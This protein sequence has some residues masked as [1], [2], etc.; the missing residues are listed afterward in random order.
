MKSLKKMVLI[1][2]VIAVLMSG[3]PTGYAYYTSFLTEG[4]TLHIYSMLTGQ[5]LY[6]MR[7][8]FFD[9]AS[10][11]FIKHIIVHLGTLDETD[12]S[13]LGSCL[14]VETITF[15]KANFKDN[16][17]PDYAFNGLH[18]LTT[19]TMNCSVVEIGKEAFKNSEKLKDVT[20]NDEYTMQ[21]VSK[22]GERAF[23]GTA[24]ENFG[25]TDEYP[26]L[27]LR[28]LETIPQYAFA[29]CGL[30]KIDFLPNVTKVEWGAFEQCPNLE[31][32]SLPKLIYAHPYAFYNC[33]KLKHVD[34]LKVTHMDKYAMK[35]CDALRE[36][37]LPELATMGWGAFE[38][39]ALLETVDMPKLEK[40]REYGFYACPKL[41]DVYLP[42]VSRLEWNAFLECSG[43]QKISL[44]N[45][46]HFGID[47]FVRCTALK[48]AIFPKAQTFERGI[49]YQCGAIT[50]L[51]LGAI[52][53]TLGPYNFDGT[54]GTKT[55]YV[56]AS[57][58]NTY[59]PE[60]DGWNT[61]Q[62]ASAS[63]ANQITSF[64]FEAFEPDIVGTI[65]HSSLTVDV[66]VPYGTDLTSLTPTI[67]ESPLATIRPF[68]GQAQDFTN[69]VV[70]T[71]MAQSGAE[72]KYTVN[73]HNALN[74]ENKILSF[75]IMDKTGVT[76]TID[77]ANKTVTIHIP[78]DQL[79]GM[80]TVD[81]EVSPDATVSPSG[82]YVDFDEPVTFTVT[83]QNGDTQDYTVSRAPNTECKIEAFGLMDWY[84]P[85]VI[86]GTIDEST[87][88]IQI[89][90]P[91]DTDLTNL[92][93]VYGLSDF[94][95]A[96]PASQAVQDFTNPV[97]YTVTAENGT[98]QAQYEVTVTE[99]APDLAVQD[100][101]WLAGDELTEAMILSK[102][103]AT[104]IAPI[105]VSDWG[106][107]NAQSPQ[108]GD[109]T[110]TIYAGKPNANIEK[111]VTVTV[112]DSVGNG[113]YNIVLK[114]KDVCEP[115]IVDGIP[116]YTVRDGKS[117]FQ[118]VEVEITPVFGHSGQET[119]VFAHYRDGALMGLYAARD[120]FDTKNNASIG[121]N[122]ASGDVIKV[123]IADSISSD[124]NTNPE[125]L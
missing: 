12:M 6:D 70:Y 71:V 100:F 95:T 110:V 63:T 122:A 48:T 50:S 5:L 88:T 102:S 47:A 16:K 7:N 22:I 21:F 44:P 65:N 67:A 41:N 101:E 58:V 17:I 72:Q 14:K 121:L 3:I 57:A 82:G 89:E 51:T 19:I 80:L 79:G 99:A 105:S 64:A 81:V 114:S 60:N 56:P 9:S 111:S 113:G 108:A 13:W 73:V 78:P 52:P 90:V 125:I 123:Y 28:N 20:L 23:E 93:P 49:F 115:G 26:Y 39:N 119:I 59:D 2:C 37:Y 77:E 18:H 30:K 120:D 40:V 8:H 98:D 85:D 116:M 97:T 92:T 4:D 61:W 74:H 109:Y 76:T 75:D 10:K 29:H 33:Q 103:N 25:G 38:T 53:P 31:S 112:H 35:D 104:S 66:T 1:V 54:P 107:L 117:G 83:A 62:V 118:F 32:I 94:A 11:D 68:S 87:K 45:T 86:M 15:I 42:T 43:L 27:A 124:P 91:Y 69:S 36:I 84:P 106:G 55:L 34:M 24:I 96:S 46:T